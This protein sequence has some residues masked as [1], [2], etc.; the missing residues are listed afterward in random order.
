MKHDTLYSDDQIRAAEKFLEEH[1]VQISLDQRSGAR[2][3]E[4]ITLYFRDTF[5]HSPKG[6]L[7]FFADGMLAVTLPSGQSEG[8]L[9][10]LKPGDQIFLRRHDFLGLEDRPS[11]LEAKVIDRREGRRQDDIPGTQVLILERKDLHIEIAR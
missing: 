9:G 10:Y 11:L 8:E 3:P 6:M 2:P 7:D 4:E 1:D 5:V